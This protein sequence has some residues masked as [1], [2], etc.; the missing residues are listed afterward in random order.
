MNAAGP[1]RGVR[2][3]RARMA[4][5][6]G[7]VNE[8]ASLP[9]AVQTRYVRRERARLDESD[10]ER[11]LR[12]H[13]YARVVAD[14]RAPT[15]AE[16]ARA[17]GIPEREARGAY[18]QLSRGHAIVLDDESGEIW[19]VAPFSAVPTDFVVVAGQRRCFANCIWDALGICAALRSDGRVL[20]SCA[21]CRAPMALAVGASGPDPGG[22]VVH[23]AIAAREWYRDIAF[24]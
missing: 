18:R 6:G 23:F 11:R 16:S 2:P 22:G 3:L 1:S 4:R 21:C 10:L 24:T 17:L 5:R 12:L 7:S 9:A 19:R 14:G 13:T 15:V 8:K 20:A